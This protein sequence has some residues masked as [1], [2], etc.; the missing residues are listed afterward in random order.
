MEAHRKLKADTA[1]E[2]ELE[3]HTEAAKEDK[4]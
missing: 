3:A 4:P 1:I 2:T